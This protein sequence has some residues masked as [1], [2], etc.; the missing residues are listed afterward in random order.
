M[1]W[2]EDLAQGVTDFG[3][4][5]VG[6]T[7][8]HD[9]PQAAPGSDAVAAQPE[10]LWGRIGQGVG[11]VVHGL[12]QEGL[13]GVLDP[14]GM[15]DRQQAQRDLA[16]RFDVV[17]DDFVG[18]RLPNQVTQSEYQDIAHT[19]SD[20]R[21]GRGDLTINTS[22]QTDPLEAARYQ[23]QVMNSIADQMMTASG[24]DTV[25]RLHD[26]VLVDDAGNP[27]LDADG[28]EQHH[29]TQ[30]RA[31]YNSNPDGDPLDTNDDGTVDANDIHD[32]AHR[33]NG[34]AYADA[35]DTSRRD[36]WFRTQRT[37]AS[38][39]PVT[40]ASGNPVMDRGAGT[41]STIWFNPQVTAGNC[42]RADVILQHEM[43][44]A[45]HETQGTMA[46]DTNGQTEA[47]IANFER[48]AVGLPNSGHYPGDADGCTENNYREERNQLGDRFLP[49]TN[50]G[51]TMPGEAATDAEAQAA[52]AAHHGTGP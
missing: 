51:G 11:D 49:R 18:P 44:H 46:S 12:Q 37:D 28:N 31:L 15:M 29:A 20:I 52:W 7:P 42:S 6:S 1:G 27:R 25:G 5:M 9:Q 13:N 22:E 16:N 38:G 14:S 2:F 32:E 40:D 33:F 47:G 35:T 8:N 21:L 41:D 3:Q 17:P 4:G 26:N 45:I 24:R 50:Y 48:Q 34:N 39:N 10:S 36:D 23:Q 19:F 43:A 30:I